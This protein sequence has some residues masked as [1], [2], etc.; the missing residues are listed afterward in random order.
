MAGHFVRG[1]AAL[2]AAI[3]AARTVEEPGV[4]VPDVS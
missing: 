3:A 1:Q 2:R 4:P